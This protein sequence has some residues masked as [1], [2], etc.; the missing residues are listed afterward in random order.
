MNVKSIFCFVSIIILLH[1]ISGCFEEEELNNEE[2][3]FVG[4]WDMV[5][6]E[7]Q[8]IFYSNGE[9]SGFV[10]EEFKIID[11]ELAILKRFAGGYKQESYNYN[12]SNNDTKLILVDIDSGVT[13]TLIKQ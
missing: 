4:K 8:V 6:L 13:H 1:C 2:N 3:R 11:G 7:S 5:G 9:L 10:G 12:F